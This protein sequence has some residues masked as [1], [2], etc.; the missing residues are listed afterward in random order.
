MNKHYVT[1]VVIALL[2]VSS[3]AVAGKDKEDKIW[4]AE[5][6]KWED[7]PIKGTH[8]AKLWGD[9][10]KG[11]AF[12]NLIKFDAGLMHP[13]HKHTHT[14]KIVMISGTMVHKAEGGSEAK[15][16]PGSFL[17]ETKPHVSGCTK[18]AD[19]VFFMTSNDKFDF[20]NLEEGG[21]DEKAPEKKK[22]E[23]KM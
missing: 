10:T 7:G 14:L 20:I 9:W 1:A 3:A 16:G 11:G 8:V 17:K 22:A 4:P 6:I 18:D 19:C 15:L 23:E 2:A 12:G 13:L 21:K 5:S